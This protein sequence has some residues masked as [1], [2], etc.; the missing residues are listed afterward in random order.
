MKNYHK[1]LII[2][3]IFILINCTNSNSENPEI[4]IVAFESIDPGYL[5]FIENEISKKFK[6]DTI[7]VINEKLPEITYYKFRNRY[8]ADKLIHYL[9]NEYAADKVIGITHKDISTTSGKHENWGIMGLA[10]RPGKSCVVS[11]FRTFRGA[12]SENHKR[13]R[14]RKVVFHEFGHTLGLPHCNNSNE[15]LMRDANGKVATV[16]E[17]IDFCSKCQMQIRPN[18]N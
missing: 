1:F 5:K 16:D 17:T 18:L 12:Q 2:I 14:L 7:Q 13:E 9:K 6:S 3:G 11:T 15:C 8:R 10:Y 4:K